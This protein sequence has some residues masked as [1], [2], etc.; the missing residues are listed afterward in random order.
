MFISEIFAIP[1]FQSLIKPKFLLTS[2]AAA[3]PFVFA[4]AKIK[5]GC[6]ITEEEKKNNGAKIPNICEHFSID[7]ENLEGFLK[8]QNWQF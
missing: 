4:S 1:H 5:Q 8:R 2:N 6:V 7:C 3:D